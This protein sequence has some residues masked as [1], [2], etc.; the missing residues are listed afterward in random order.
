ML[1]FFHSPHTRSTRILALLLAMD[2]LDRVDLRPV[3]IPRIDGTGS[4]DSRNPHPEGKVPLLVQDGVAIWES[5]A[6]MLHLTDL[7][8]ETGLGVLA[9]DPG[10]GRYLSWLS[11]YAGVMEPVLILDAAG[12]S[13]PFLSASLRG[14]G[15]VRQRL[16]SALD[17]GPWLMGER[18]TAADLLVASPFQWFADLDAG[19]DVT[20]D[21]VARCAAQPWIAAATAMDAQQRAA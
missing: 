4:R 16:A 21:W 17:D 8:P 7:F 18:Y 19:S 9:G 14:V 20:R 2:R 11:W 5:A 1:T 3:T 12:L 6:I 15:E 13:H 10:R